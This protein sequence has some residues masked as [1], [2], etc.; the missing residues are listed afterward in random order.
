[1]GLGAMVMLKRRWREGNGKMKE[2]EREPP[3]RRRGTDMRFVNKRGTVARAKIKI[4]HIQ[5]QFRKNHL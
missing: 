4:V 2:G 5:R 1:M 3:A